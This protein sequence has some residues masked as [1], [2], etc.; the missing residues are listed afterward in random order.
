MRASPVIAWHVALFCLLLG[1]AAPAGAAQ[2]A[3]ATPLDKAALLKT[4]GASE[5]P[6]DE[7]VAEIGKRGVDFRP[8][9]QDEAKLT[10]AG[11]G[12]GLLA[13]VRAGYR[14]AGSP[15]SLADL[16][17]L[18]ELRA[19]RVNLEALIEARGV[20]FATT[21]QIASQILAA[22][23]DSALVGLVLLR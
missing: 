11:A 14:P 7:L 1:I 13:A 21:P 15:L 9:A 3:P 19:S 20:D 17:M 16:R 5:R 10:S 23:G 4:L 12:P 6:Q 22:G 18:L 8:T 2:T